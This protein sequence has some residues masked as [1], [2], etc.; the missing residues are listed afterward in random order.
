MHT[1]D[2]QTA[3]SPAPVFGAVVCVTDRSAGSA[4][5]V[6]QAAHL[7]RE[8][9]R[10]ELV[11]LAPDPAPGRP[12]PQ[13]VQIE[14][15]VEG[16]AVASRCG[17]Q[18]TVHIDETSDDVEAVVSRCRGHGLLV[19]PAGPLA[20][21][22]LPRADLP[23]LVTRP[24]REFPGSVLIAVDGTPEAHAA[25]RLG[26]QLAARENALTAL[27]ASPEH[28]G[29]H[30]SALEEDVATVERLTGRRPVILDEHGPAA[31]SIVAAATALEASLVV[32][33][34]RPGRPVA[35]VS[36]AVVA[37]APCSVLVIRPSSSPTSA[38]R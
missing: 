32:L 27:V 12:R 6:R 21:A 37:H 36:A 33:G 30:Q 38:P 7:A 10:L 9:G 22:V 28:D 2:A 8:D 5:A 17:V 26:A 15:L 1:L 14:S 11:A 29:R 31:P 16:A 13:A 24:A 4:E 20:E 34:S 25:T 19:L 23:V 35:S 18:A 3:S